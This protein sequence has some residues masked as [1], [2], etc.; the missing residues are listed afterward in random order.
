MRKFM[1]V[2]R[3]FEYCGDN[4]YT[5]QTTLAYQRLD[6]PKAFM[7]TGSIMLPAAFVKLD[8]VRVLNI[9]AIEKMYEKTCWDA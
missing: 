8:L 1:S 6:Y 2:D 7:G 4:R 9:D 3:Y 5:T